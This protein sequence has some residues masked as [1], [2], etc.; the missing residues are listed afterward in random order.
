L[1]EYSRCG[2]ALLAGEKKLPLAF[3]I[4][5]VGHNARLKLAQSKL[6]LEMDLF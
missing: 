5:G 6:I 3:H 2:R 4:K 1:D